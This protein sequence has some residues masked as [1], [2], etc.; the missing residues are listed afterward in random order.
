MFK[1]KKIKKI[2]YFYSVDSVGIT[3]ELIE[4][5]Y[6]CFHETLNRLLLYQNNWCEFLLLRH[7][8]GN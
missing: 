3:Y 5:L 4:M 7:L 8:K 2:G 1:G 6:C